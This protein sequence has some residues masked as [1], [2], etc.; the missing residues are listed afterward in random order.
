[1]VWKVSGCCFVHIWACRFNL[2]LWEGRSET[3]WKSR[4]SYVC[5]K[6]EAKAFFH[7]YFKI[8]NSV[9]PSVVGWPGLKHLPVFPARGILRDFVGT[10]RGQWCELSPHGLSM[11]QPL[12]TAW[13]G[14]SPLC[15]R[16]SQIYLPQGNEALHTE[17]L[18]C[19][20]LP[21]VFAY[22]SEVL[23]RT[24]MSSLWICE[25]EKQQ[26]PCRKCLLL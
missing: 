9:A 26:T 20:F 3:S 21:K 7:F 5:L 14:T 22:C 11:C 8:K 25:K 6:Q 23:V 24:F 18:R 16:R 4:V 1:M 10:A 13:A 2:Q 15:C 19:I 12:P 17:L